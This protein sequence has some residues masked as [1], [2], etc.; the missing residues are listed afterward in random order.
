MFRIF[1][2]YDPRQPV[3]LQVLMHSIYARASIPVAITPLVLSTLPSKRR[4]LTEFTYS[5]YLTPYLCNF[6]G[7]A[8]F[9]DADMLCLGD[10]AE[11]KS[12][13]SQAAV[14]VVKNPALRF[15]W[16]SLMLF[17]CTHP[18]NRVLMPDFINSPESKPNKLEW[19]TPGDLPAIWNHCVGYDAPNPYAKVVHF[20]CGIPCFEE[21][22][23]CEF[24]KEWNDE[25]YK[26][27]SI[28]SWE[29]LMGNS[30]HVPRV[31]RGFLNDNAAAAN[32]A[33]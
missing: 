14:S 1:I 13:A 5:R 6:E 7:T 21:T 30:V 20:T 11:L 24:S 31:K 12:Y 18:D 10:V 23:D 26:S 15:E 27:I 16:P 32:P 8:A 33:N 28:V 29:E 22:K 9:F 25:A 19:T 17:D 3:A 4:G 2:G